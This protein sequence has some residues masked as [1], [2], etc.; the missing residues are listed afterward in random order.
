MKRVLVCLMS[1]VNALA[2]VVWPFFLVMAGGFAARI[3]W[4][5]QIL[6]L[7]GMPLG[8]AAFVWADRA[9]RRP[10]MVV[11]NALGV[12]FQGGF[13]SWYLFAVFRS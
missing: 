8:I 7:V 5:V 13:W 12:L 11:A 4:W 1:S 9:P 3:E 6:I 10:V 2:V